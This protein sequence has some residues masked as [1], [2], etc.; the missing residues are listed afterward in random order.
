MRSPAGLLLAFFL[1]SACSSSTSPTPAPNPGS[2]A[3]NDAAGTDA[4][5][6]KC[7][8]AGHLCS[9]ADGTCP[10]GYAAAGA[11]ELSCAPAAPNCCI[12]Q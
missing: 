3:G 5:N 10:P 4:G 11:L 12:K 6:S 8:A 2:D 9:A 1:A 7:A